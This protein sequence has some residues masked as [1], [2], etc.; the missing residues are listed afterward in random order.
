VKWNT[1]QGEIYGK[2]KKKLTSSTK[3]G[4]HKVNASDDDP[5]Y[6]TE[7]EK[8][9]NEH[10]RVIGLSSGFRQHLADNPRAPPRGLAPFGMSPSW[11]YTWRRAPKIEE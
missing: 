9:G 10:Q 2:V 7:S 11:G 8:S 6:L 4:G 5:R 1:Q 3:I